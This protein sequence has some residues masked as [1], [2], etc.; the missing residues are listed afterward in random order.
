MAWTDLFGWNRSWIFQYATVGER[1]TKDRTSLEE[2]D[3]RHPGKSI[4]G[5]FEISNEPLGSITIVI[6]GVEGDREDVG[7]CIVMRLSAVTC[8]LL[9]KPVPDLLPDVLPV[10]FRQIVFR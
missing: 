3:A 8:R 6:G 4:G 1:P 9:V 5:H 2:L 7:S 10:S